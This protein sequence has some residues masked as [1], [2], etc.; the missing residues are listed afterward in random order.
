M[1]GVGV[2]AK[3]RF[4]RRSAGGGSRKTLGARLH[5]SSI[6]WPVISVLEK[7]SWWAASVRFRT[8][9]AAVSRHPRHAFS[10]LGRPGTAHSLSVRSPSARCCWICCRARRTLKTCQPGTASA[11]WNC[12]HPF[13]SRVL[14]NA[15]RW[16]AAIV[17]NDRRSDHGRPQRA[18]HGGHDLFHVGAEPRRT[19]ATLCAART[20]AGR[21]HFRERVSL[22]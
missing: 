9:G 2:I 20:Y 19:H 7:T 3:Q 13:A 11:R 21:Q 16:S 4:S 18:R 15:I 17:R 5:G 1:P 14:Q 6:H 12:S 8:P 10:P 22:R